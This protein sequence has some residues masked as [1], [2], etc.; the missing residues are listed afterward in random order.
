VV[1][2]RGTTC[3]VEIV[4]N[5]WSLAAP[6]INEKKGFGAGWVGSIDA[7]G[8]PVKPVANLSAAPLM[9]PETD[10]DVV[11]KAQEAVMLFEDLRN[12]TKLSETTLPY[13]VVYIVNKYDATCGKAIEANTGRLD[14][15]IGEGIMAIFEASDSIEMNCKRGVK[16]ASEISK[17]IK[18]LSQDLSKEFSAEVKC[19]MAI[20]TGQ[21]IVGMMG[22]GD[23]VSR[24]A[25]G[26]NVNVASR[27]EQMTKA[28]NSD[29]IIFKQV[30]KQ[31][32]L[33]TSEFVEES[34]E[35]RGR[36]EKL[37]IVS[38]PDASQL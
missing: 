2:G 25:I 34:V 4:S 38:T 26:Y 8:L 5:D 9:N 16:A 18:M 17:Q 10:F 35:V 22:Y 6:S 15:F 13:D 12:F 37:D 32:A 11:E 3:R 23:T 36:N 14:K 29:L 31:A 28:Y 19:G 21:S 27:L 24:T 30:A 7:A 33:K 1:V 20:H